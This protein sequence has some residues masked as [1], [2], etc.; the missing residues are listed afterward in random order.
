[1][2]F[3]LSQALWLLALG[4]VGVLSAAASLDP[5][6][7]IYITSKQDAPASSS[8]RRLLSSSQIDFVLSLTFD[9][10]LVGSYTSMKLQV[11]SM[12]DIHQLDN[13][14]ITLPGFSVDSDVQP[15]PTALGRDIGVDGFLGS[16]AARMSNFMENVKIVFNL[17]DLNNSLQVFKNFSFV[18][19]A[20]IS[21]SFS[22]CGRLAH[23][24]A[25]GCATLDLKVTINQKLQSDDVIYLR[26]LDFSSSSGDII[27]GSVVSKRAGA[28]L[29]RSF[30]PIRRASWSQLDGLLMIHVDETIVSNEAIEVFVPSTF[31][32]R[33]PLQGV[34]PGMW[35]ARLGLSASWGNVGLFNF[36]SCLHVPR[37]V[38][39]FSRPV[40]REDTSVTFGVTLSFD[41][42]PSDD[43]ILE[44]P[45][46][47]QPPLN[48]SVDLTEYLSVFH[49][50]QKLSSTFSA[51]FSPS[52]SL[53]LQVEPSRV[54]QDV[55][56][57]SFSIVPS[58]LRC[59]GY[60]TTCCVTS[61]WVNATQGSRLTLRSSRLLPQGSPL[62]FLVNRS[63]LL[64]PA[65]IPPKLE[66]FSMDFSSQLWSG[67]R[68]PP[69]GPSSAVPVEVLQSVGDAPLFHLDF[70]PRVASSSS[71]L[72]IQVKTSS[73]LLPGERVLLLLSGFA[74][75]STCEL[76]VTAN[77]SSSVKLRT[78]S[79]SCTDETL[80][81][82]FAVPVAA[83]I[84]LDVN[85]SRL[86][87][88]RIPASGVALNSPELRLSVQAMCGAVTA[89]VVQC[90]G[91]G[92][93]EKSEVT[94]T[95]PARAGEV[96]GVQL[97]LSYQSPLSPQDVV[98]FR[99]FGF[100][101]A[102]Q[103]PGD[104]LTC[105]NSSQTVASESAR[106]GGEERSLV[107]PGWY[108]TMA[109]SEEGT[110]LLLLLS[111]NSTIPA[112]ELIQ[113]QVPLCAGVQLPGEGV[114]ASTRIE[115]MIDSSVRSVSWIPSSFPLIGKCDLTMDILFPSAGQVSPL[116]FRFS[117]SMPIAR[118]ESLSI[119][120]PS[121][122]LLNV[123]NSS[124]LDLTANLLAGNFSWNISWSS[125]TLIITAN[126]LIPPYQLESLLLS[127]SAGLH[128]PPQGVQARSP[129]LTF[130]SD[131]QA[132][133]IAETGGWSPGLGAFLLS[134][135]G[136]S[137]AR[138]GSNAEVV[139][140][141]ELSAD[142]LEGEDVVVDLREM[143]GGQLVGELSVSSKTGSEAQ[144]LLAE[145]GMENLRSDENVFFDLLYQNNIS[146]LSSIS[147]SSSS[148]SFHVTAVDNNI[149]ADF[150]Q[151]LMDCCSPRTLIFMTGS[152]GL[153]A[154]HLFA[155]II[156]FGSFAIARMLVER[157]EADP[158]N[159][160]KLKLDL[161]TCMDVE[162]NEQLDL[163]LPGFQQ[164]GV[165]N[166]TNNYISFSWDPSQ[167]KLNGILKVK[168]M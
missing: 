158:F 25:A 38:L 56:T 161:K 86:E 21:L 53:A 77:V 110:A 114:L 8:S 159:M 98:I 99:L 82:E 95:P 28:P 81:L 105:V 107:L 130:S 16:D 137:P 136:V 157:K 144:T 149:P 50:E 4:V 74:T 49:G 6:A 18:K 152:K 168:L 138:A 117:C 94:F 71:S 57:S 84:Q 89:R 32:L 122:F 91:V 167:Q 127:S 79:W 52:S 155:H 96:A 61:S 10:I 116:A 65:P 83:G 115:M 154:P 124:L 66:S 88:L 20:G 24:I 112:L 60:E 132:G 100:S 118:G 3:N 14:A 41:L 125:P 7:T 64:P 145:F 30:S 123:S 93:V 1:M 27:N 78:A 29:G 11:T 36:E 22:P 9:P 13:I 75:N 156:A 135:V 72:F 147:S 164:Q 39:E 92:V 102:P 142:V 62:L 101:L 85:V 43:I 68:P 119:R 45:L 90:V 131:A 23:S 2:S 12:V 34:T 150:R 146:F 35:Q 129:L 106:V 104:N 166:L 70:A 97:S 103:T 54:C 120:L 109:L 5:E 165:F 63:F 58:G 140:L 139:M 47:P 17:R 40:L 108:L 153:A 151:V 126:H 134:Y 59:S 111:P 31:G 51:L 76:D 42:Y 19:F 121:F 162:V 48:Q 46:L 113:L 133:A 80:L 163:L 73:L 143:L 148:S 160:Q 67:L 33:F 141:W 44:L 87:E 26:L 37:S 69:F 15:D 128:L 55:N